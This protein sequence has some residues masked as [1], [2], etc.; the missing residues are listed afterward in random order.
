[1]DVDVE[2]EDGAP[3]LLELRCRSSDDH[4][5][6]ECRERSRTVEERPRPEPEPLVAL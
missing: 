5:P 3:R 1:M 2:E 6:V 4:L